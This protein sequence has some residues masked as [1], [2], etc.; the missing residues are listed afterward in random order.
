MLQGFSLVDAYNDE[1]KK[2]GPQWTPSILIPQFPIFSIWRLI[3]Y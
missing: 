2:K 3:V 1:G